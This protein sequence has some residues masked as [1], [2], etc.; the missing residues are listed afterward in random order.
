[1]KMLVVM[2]VSAAARLCQMY[3]YL[4]EFRVLYEEMPFKIR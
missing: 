3:V 2:H 4:E 1:M